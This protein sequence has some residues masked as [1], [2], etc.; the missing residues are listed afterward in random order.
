MASHQQV[1]NPANFHFQWTESWYEWD[2][3][4]AHKAALAARNKEARR[5]RKQ[6]RRVVCETLRG[7]TI[8][9]GGIGTGHPQIDMVVS[10][11]ML[12][13]IG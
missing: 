5:L 8:T 1:F 10:G 7:Q 2:R 12:T 6:G 9:R 13:V 4:A 11:Y 3:K